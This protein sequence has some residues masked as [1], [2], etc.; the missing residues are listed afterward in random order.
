M[1]RENSMVIVYLSILAVILIVYFAIH[2]ISNKIS[3]SK[4]VECP[5]C[6]NYADI[7]SVDPEYALEWLEQIDYL[8][9]RY[10][11]ED[12]FQITAQNFFMSDPVMIEEVFLY[13][14]DIQS[15]LRGRG[16]TIVEPKRDK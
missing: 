12:D 16:W 3:Q 15:W 14:D 4:Q 10:I 8:E 9:G 2:F 1:K 7:Y 5:V 13:D 11:P 6:G